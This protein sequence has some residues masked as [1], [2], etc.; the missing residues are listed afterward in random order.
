MGSLGVPEMIF[1]FVLALLIFGPKKLPEV[2]KTIGKAMSEFRRASS[3]LKATFDREMKTLE[4]ETESIKEVANDYHNDTYNYDYSS[5][6]SGYYGSESQDSTATEVSTASASA[7]QGAESHTAANPPEGTVAH[8]TETAAVNHSAV[9]GA[10]NG[11]VAKPA[12]VKTSADAAPHPA[13]GSS[14][15]TEH[16]A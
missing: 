13:I 7:T 6:D 5:Y 11:S 2:G 10:S 15:A 14:E 8:G 12:E 9:E 16:K 4:R 1:I 3:D